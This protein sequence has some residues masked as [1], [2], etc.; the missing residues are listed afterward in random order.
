MRRDAEIGSAL[1]DLFGHGKTDLG[2]FGNP[3]VVVGDC[4]DRH[5][6][7]LDQRQHHFE[8]LFFAGDGVEERAAF[9]SF[10]TSNQ[11]TRHRR[12]DAER[13][14]GHGLHALDEFAHQVGFNKVVVRITRVFGHFVGEDSTRVDVENISP[15][16]NL[17]QG[18]GLNAGKIAALKLFVEDLTA[19]GVD[20]LTDNGK[21]LIKSHDRGF[22]FRF[23]DST[24]HS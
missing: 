1:N 10:E 16:G 19:R 8:T 6:V 23:N 4:H 24:G 9:G 5:V 11:R 22:C 12:V 15:G 17:C 18:V 7:F 13:T 3:G 2:V 14:V 20:P 21:R